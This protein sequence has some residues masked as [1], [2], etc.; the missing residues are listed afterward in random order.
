MKLQ[1]SLNT[2]DKIKRFANDVVKFESDIY[3]I[4]NERF[5]NAKSILS[6]MV[7]LDMSK[8]IDIQIMSFDSQ[9]IEKFKSVMEE[10][11]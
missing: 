4:R 9:E 3:F 8:N 6:V 11:K 2:A 10:Y 5:Y 1:I 7:L